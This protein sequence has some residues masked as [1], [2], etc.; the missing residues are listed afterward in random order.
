ME[1]QHGK[2]TI[3]HFMTVDLRVGTVELAERVPNSAR[4]LR[5]IVDIG[6]EKRQIVAGI[7][8]SYPPEELVGKQ[9]I[10]VCNLQPAVLRG[11]ESQGMLLAA[12]VGGKPKI[13]TF[14]VPVPPGTRVR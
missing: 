8:D 10:V 9:V 14:Q 12:D 1:T 2:I 4:L 7:A 3:D 6:T 13:A 11:V 5:L